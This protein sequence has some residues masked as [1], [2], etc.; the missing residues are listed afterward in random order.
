MI[1]KFVRFKYTKLSGKLFNLL[2]FYMQETQP[3]PFLTAP[4]L[5]DRLQGKE[6][7]L[8][9]LTDGGS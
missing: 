5:P 2:A 7:S 9:S 3:A 6:G 1:L 4:A 8:S